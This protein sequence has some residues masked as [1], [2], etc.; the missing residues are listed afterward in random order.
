MKISAPGLDFISRPKR[1]CAPGSRGP[2]S[3]TASLAPDHSV[4][5]CWWTLSPTTSTTRPRPLIRRWVARRDADADD[6]D[7]SHAARAATVDRSAVST[8]SILSHRALYLAP[9]NGSAMLREGGPMLR[10]RALRCRALPVLRS[11]RP[12]GRP[13]RKHS[14]VITEQQRRAAEARR[15][16]I[17]ARGGTT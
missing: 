12:Q 5:G 2:S 7:L 13:P 8:T 6:S 16:R 9:S 17:A 14:E 3:P 10:A 1:V 15:H 4:T 11:V